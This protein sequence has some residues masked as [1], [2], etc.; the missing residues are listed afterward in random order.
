MNYIFVTSVEGKTRFFE[1]D[2]EDL[3]DFLNKDTGCLRTDEVESS[4]RYGS[5]LIVL[6]D[7]QKP[8]KTV[9]P[10]D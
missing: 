2:H 5:K 7:L 9:D 10:E 1:I 3:V 8:V 4:I 6:S